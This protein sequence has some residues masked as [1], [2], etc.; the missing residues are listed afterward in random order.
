MPPRLQAS[1]Q[2]A[3]CSHTRSK[4]AAPPAWSQ[5]PWVRITTS[6]GLLV[7]PSKK[8]LR[9]PAPV[10]VSISAARS[11][12]STKNTATPVIS[13]IFVVL[14]LTFSVVKNSMVFLLLSIDSRS[15]RILR[16]RGGV[17]WGIRSLLRRQI[18][19][20]NTPKGAD[21][22]PL[23]NHSHFDAPAGLLW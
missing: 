7:K 11:R 22:P 12:P 23:Q 15:R 14:G 6:R 17:K 10:A 16:T 8:D 5:W 18:P 1:S 2:S 20:E 13:T 19:P 9:S 21:S 4:P 3:L